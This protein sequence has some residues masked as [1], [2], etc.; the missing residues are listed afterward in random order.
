MA[1]ESGSSV[2]IIGMGCRFPGGVHD[3]D[4]LW[5]L[6]STGGDA[7]VDVPAD[8]WSTDRFFSADPNVPGKTYVRRAG[9]LS[10]PID[11]FDPLFFGISPREAEHMDPQQRLLLEVGWETIEEAG[12]IPGELAGSRTGV[13]VGGFAL[14]AMSILM[15]PFARNHIDSHHSATAASMTMLAARLSYIFDFRGPSVTMDTA[16]SSSLVALHYACRALINDECDMAMAG[17]VNIM[18]SAEYPI[19]MCKGHFLARDGHCKS[20]DAKADGYS[21]G[22]GCGM[23]LLK[24]L[25]DAL[26]DGDRVHAVICGTGVNQDGRTDGITVPS[27]AAQEALIREVYAKADVPLSAVSY[28]EAHGTGTPI[29]DPL[30]AEALGRTIGAG[31]E[32]AQPLIIGSVKA[33]IGHLEAAAGVAGVIKAC[34]CLR[35]R[36]VPRQIHLTEP[37]PTIPFEALGLKL[38]LELLRLPESVDTPLC[39][40]V[41]SFGYGGTNAHAILRAPPPAAPPAVNDEPVQGEAILP[42]SARSEGALRLQV[43]SCIDALGTPDAPP[44]HRFAA[45]MASQRSHFEHRIAVRGASNAEL[46]ARLRAYLTDGKAEG[47]A[48]GRPRHADPCPAV[49]VYTGM[50]P[51]WWGMGQA[52]YESNAVFRVAADEC[53]AAFRAVSGWSVLDEMRAPEAQSR[54]SETC[55]AQPANFVLQVALTALLREEGVVP[56]AIVGHSVGE[57]AAAHLAGALTLEEAARVVFH[58]SRLQQTTAGT[59]TMLAIGIGAA[60]AR[61]WLRGFEDDVS[62]GAVNSHRSLTL[63]GKESALRDIAGRLGDAEV[64]HRFLQVEVPYHSPLMEPL[65]TELTE[66]LA[67]L[68]ARAPSIPLY[69]TVTGRRWGDAE[70]HDGDY[71]FRN[72]RDP[73]L[74]ADAVDA[75]IA[76]GHNLFVEVGPHPVLASAI[77]DQLAARHV[78]GDTVFSLRRQDAEASRIRGLIGEL[79]TL[80]VQP[81]WRRINGRAS[82]CTKLPT[83]R[84]QREVYWSESLQSRADRLGTSAHP[85][86]GPPLPVAAA[87]AW[88]TDLNANYLP[89]LG[90]HVIEDM[91]VFPGAGYVEACLALHAAVAD[92][93]PAIIENLE[94]TNALTLK[95]LAG[96]ELQWSFDPKTRVC[97]A[98]SR[99]HGEDQAWQNHATASILNSSPWRATPRDP[100]A[101]EARCPTQIDIGQLYAELATRGLNYGLAFQCVR[102]LRRGESEV[103]ARL[104]LG[105]AEATAVANYRIHP[106][107]LDAAFQALI[108]TCAPGDDGPSLF[109]PVAIRQVLFHAPVGA[110][111]LA[112]GRLIL[113]SDE[114]IEGDV[115]LFADDGTVSIEVKGIRCR[116]VGRGDQRARLPLDRWMYDYV[117]EQSEPAAGFADAARWLI[118][119]DQDAVGASLSKHLQG[120]GAESVIQVLP[121]E[122]YTRVD[123][124]RFEIRRG[125]REDMTR[126]L[127]EARAHESRAIMY[128]WGLEPPV[129]GIESDPAGVDAFGDALVMVQ[130]LAADPA[131]AGL[132]KRP[133]LYL[134]T[135]DAQPVDPLRPITGLRHASLVGFMRVIAIEQPDFRPTLIDLGEDLPALAA[136]RRLGQE[137]LADSAEDAVALRGTNRWVQRLARRAE[138]RGDDVLV[139]LAGLGRKA[140]YGLVVPVPGRL[141]RVRY[142]EQPRTAPKENEIELHIRAVG[143]NFKDVLKVLGVLSKE[144]LAGTH[145]GMTLGMEAAAVVTAVGPGVTGYRVGDEI[146][147]LVAGCLASH[148]TVRIDQLVSVPRPAALSPG[149]AATIP[150]AFMTAYYGLQEAARLRRGETV[151]IHAAAGGVGMAAIQVARWIG[152]RIFATAG[153]AE[154]REQL[155]ALGVERVWDSRSL[156]FV[157]GVREAT[158]G[159]GVDVVLN[160]LSGEAMERSFDALAP[161]GRFVEIGKRDIMEKARLPMAAFDRSVSFTAVDLDRLTL[162]SQEVVL[163]LFRETWERFEA[164]DFAPLPVTRFAAAKVGEALRYMAQAKQVGKIVVDFDDETDVAIAPLATPRGRIRADRAYLVTGGFGGVGIQLALKLAERGARHLVLTGRSGAASAAARA[165]LGQ[166]ADA[167]VQVHEARVDVSDAVALRA[168]IGQVAAEMP[169]LAGVFHAAAVLDDSLIGNLDVERARR[170]LGPKAVGALR[171]HE[172]TAHL[173]LDLFVLFSSATSLIGNPG[174][175]AYVAAN[176][177][178]DALAAQRRAQGLAATAINWGAIGDVGML[179]ED[180]AATRQLELAGVRRI[181]VA[182]AL[183][184]MFRV[185]E[186]DVG[187]VAVMDVDWS[188]WMSVFPMARSLPRFAPFAAEASQASAGADYRAALMSIPAPE[189]LPMLSTAMVELVAASLHVPADKIN[190]RQP[191]AELG[192]DSLVALELQSAINGKL[193]MQ[194]SVLQLI[195]GGNIEEM[196]A[197][198]LQKLTATGSVAAAAAPAIAVE[199]DAAPAPVAPKSKKLAA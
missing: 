188:A 198:L 76:D 155:L 1:V 26:R 12:L 67:T 6:L 179:A 156:E 161:L 109:M 114:A 43:Q 130:A 152:A 92:A 115:V 33:N 83:Y 61:D 126:L 146:I 135:R 23:V 162:S 17:G 142:A 54:M 50:G 2:A 98:S 138:N 110:R 183:E 105:E 73:V 151:L 37:N 169:P 35:H 190:P 122:A 20:F 127:T 40:G 191:L 111:A 154:K 32:S 46:A 10:N 27:A 129:G 101:I 139:P 149:D 34:L 199:T 22:E 84:W 100:G 123:E 77:R 25:D 15:S 95:P 124:D 158:G 141:D 116:A 144:S 193:G 41:N 29:G 45:A 51:Q 24:R 133:R 65:R 53:D 150:I 121:G 159:R 112:H 18:L 16:C 136:G 177:C 134:A 52:L 145:Y 140:A 11:R 192:I 79:Y 164:G 64:F 147:T 39:V 68:R 171:L 62:I 14:D 104:E 184:A 63:A 168:L 8:R 30:E 102:A 13:F 9:F 21:R 180:N 91:T 82:R 90:D 170:V 178:L 125:S 48:A 70:R 143:L 120:Q 99:A 175:S 94:F 88:V 57:V 185:L 60:E 173:D 132:D 81:D 117:W 87:N 131:A 42:I 172:S 5:T 56:A 71:W 19:I 36:Q 186:L 89:W 196:A 108:A 47:V 3:P 85:L 55:V 181:P 58:R 74:F 148:V 163:R 103:M 182:D 86:L 157:D 31:R 166:L 176:A 7:I 174:Q 44:A 66:T 160:S 49:F 119:T 59:G 69:S 167:G 118:F 96:V 93:E 194:I 137:M 72:V 78:L 195:K 28:V 189:R 113:Q 97:T 38:P 197:M 187:S 4:D 75:L 153:S 128:L 107:L 165:A 80:G 106:A